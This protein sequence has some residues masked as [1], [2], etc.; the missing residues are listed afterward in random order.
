[1]VNDQPMFLPMGASLGFLQDGRAVLPPYEVCCR[2]G[3]AWDPVTEPFSEEALLERAFAWLNTA[4]LWGG[5]SLFG[6]DCSGFV[7]QLFRFFEY[8]LPRDAWQQ[9]EQ[10]SPIG[11]LEESI[12]G[13]LAF[14]DN[15]EGRIV[16]V[17]M[18]LK[19]DTI[20]HASGKVRIDHIDHLGILHAQTGERTHTL[21]L[22]KRFLRK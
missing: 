5:R 6:V 2:D 16:H 4:Y 9:A 22:I 19:P 17:G 21:R 12:C 14:F 7:Q 3:E 15:A 20:I 8:P 10:G 11:F 1:L 13:D 18:L